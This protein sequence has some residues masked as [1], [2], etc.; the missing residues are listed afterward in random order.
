MFVVEPK[1]HVI[2]EKNEKLLLLKR[3][4]TGC[5]DG[6][7]CAPTGRIERGE[8]PSQAGSREVREEVNL[9]VSLSFITILYAKVPN[10]FDPAQPE[11]TDVCFFFHRTLKK[12]EN[13]TNN[14]PEKHSEMGWFAFNNLPDNLMPVTKYGIES[15]LKNKPYTEVGWKGELNQ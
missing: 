6:Y 7:W 14:E 12:E 9:S 13:P 15:Y 5:Y 4:N 2:L 8:S 11:Y 3:C 1:V 10:A